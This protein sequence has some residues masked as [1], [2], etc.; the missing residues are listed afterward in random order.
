MRGLITDRQQSNVDRLKE[1]SSK[2]WSNMTDEEKAEWIG[3]PKVKDGANLFANGTY[4]L[5]GVQMT[6]RLN[7]MMATA[8]TG[9]RY[10]YA[11][12][13]LGDA[14]EFE[15]KTVTLSVGG[16]IKSTGAV[17]RIALYWHNDGGIYEFAGVQLNNPGTVTA[18]LT[19]NAQNR[20]YLAAYV[21]VSTDPAVDAGVT[22]R[23]EDVML[24]FGNVKYPFV[25]YSDIIATEATKGAY[26]YSDLN[27]VEM[28]VAE[29]SDMYALSLVTKT[30]WKST[31][32]P[33]EA[34]MNRYLA[35]LRKIRSICKDQASLPVLPLSMKGMTYEAA[36]NIEKILIAAYEG[37]VGSYRSGE[38]YSGE[39]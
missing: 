31:D 5:S 13:I 7:H 25:P 19:E 26:N 30:D 11:G 1:L 37:A 36:N 34:S 15:G 32:V 33:D 10:Q 23:Y 8:R 20:Q 17:S 39:V 18:Q 3:D 9:G 4:R 29:L 14:S 24:T 6:Y 22:V 35:N 12:I 27:R 2:G 28:A 38:V 16:M 21:Y